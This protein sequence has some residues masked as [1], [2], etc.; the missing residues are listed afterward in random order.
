MIIVCKQQAHIFFIFCGN[1]TSI[2]HL[3]L[4]LCEIAFNDTNQVH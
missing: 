2:S 3:R 4:L 1:L